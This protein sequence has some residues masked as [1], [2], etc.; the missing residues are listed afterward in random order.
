MNVNVLAE[1]KFFFLETVPG[2]WHPEAFF[3]SEDFFFTKKHAS[4]LISVSGIV[5]NTQ[6]QHTYSNVYLVYFRQW[7]AVMLFS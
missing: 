6:Q 7:H 4:D 2:P 1:N 3:M 5:P